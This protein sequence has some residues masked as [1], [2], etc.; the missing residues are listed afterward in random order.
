MGGAWAA[1]PGHFGYDSGTVATPPRQYPHPMP[2][3]SVAGSVSELASDTARL[4]Q[5]EIEL[6]Q[7]ERRRSSGVT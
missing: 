7:Q 2:S 3:D 5:L 6:V 4:V 1:Q